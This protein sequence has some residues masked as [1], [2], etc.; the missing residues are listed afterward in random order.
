M[1]YLNQTV[2]MKRWAYYLLMLL[3]FVNM[4][5]LYVHNFY[6]EPQCTV[7]IDEPDQ[8]DHLMPLETGGSG[9]VWPQRI[10]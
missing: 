5:D 9:P 8:I 3:V 7:M 1:N 4:V 10:K 6:P 2:N